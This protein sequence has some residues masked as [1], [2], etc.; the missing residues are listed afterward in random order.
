MNIELILMPFFRTGPQEE[1]Y[2]SRVIRGKGYIHSYGV[3]IC[4]GHGRDRFYPWHR[5]ETVLRIQSDI[6]AD[7]SRKRE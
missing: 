7:D 6:E 1:D 3:Q 4:Y 5:I 2:L